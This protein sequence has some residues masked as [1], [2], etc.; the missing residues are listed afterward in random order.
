MTLGGVDAAN[1]A[2]LRTLKFESSIDLTLG[3][4]DAA[5]NAELRTLKFE[6]STT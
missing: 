5:N 1:N 4:I 3:G 6:L 2:E